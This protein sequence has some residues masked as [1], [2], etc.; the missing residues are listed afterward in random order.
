MQTVACT[1][2][3]ICIHT[4]ICNTIYNYLSLNCGLSTFS[5]K[6]QAFDNGFEEKGEKFMEKNILKKWQTKCK[7]RETKIEK[8]EKINQKICGKLK[9]MKTVSI[10]SFQL[11]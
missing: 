5:N 10:K 9:S 11:S 1:H 7:K 3:Y 4:Y 2:A 8:I 6:C